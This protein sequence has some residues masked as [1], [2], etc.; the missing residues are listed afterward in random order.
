M[1][2]RVVFT[3]EPQLRWISHLDL[4]KT[5][6]KALRRAQV[7]LA[8]SQGFN[9]RPKMSIAAPLALGLSSK[10]ELLDFELQVRVDL[11]ALQTKI[12]EHLP[13][14]LE[15]IQLY[16][17][18]SKGPSLMSLVTVSHYQ[19]RFFKSLKVLELEKIV[20]LINQKEELLFEVEQKR[21]TRTID[22][23]PGIFALYTTDDCGE[24]FLNAVL[25]TSSSR[26]IRPNYI[27]D[28]INEHLQEPLE[29]EDY[30]IQREKILLKLK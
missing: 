20:E 16:E 24:I 13:E 4:I 21:R 6:E 10:S 8:L 9:P 26:F 2:V 5:I 30:I 11:K 17:V 1:K 12:N 25:E 28:L 27:V 18:P 3:K 29:L 7:P 23:K 19:F 14:G 22:L 15:F